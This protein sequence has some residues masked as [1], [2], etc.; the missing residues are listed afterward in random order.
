MLIL[1]SP[2]K[3]LDFKPTGVTTHTLPDFLNDS[4]KLIR[5]MKK[6]SIGDLQQLMSISEALASLN[7]QRYRQ[8][9]FPFTKENAKQAV[10]A[11]KGDV[12]VGLEADTL[13]EDDLSF[14]QDHV[15]ILSGLYGMLKPLDLIQPYRLEMGVRLEQG[16]YS[17]LYEFW[18]QKLTR[19]LNDKILQQPEDTR[20][21]INLASQEYFQ[22]IRTAKV[23]APVINIKFLEDRGGDLQFISFNA[24][25]AR[26]IMTRFIIRHRLSDPEAIKTFN[27]SS[28]QY[29]D[30]LSSANEWT[31]IRQQDA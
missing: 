9:D 28:Y 12:Y 16:K 10:L 24:K 25:K 11:F 1:L 29:A 15:I 5:V 13:D 26:G 22:A 2:A 4:K 8:F 3:T 19:H 23:K 18:T 31:F 7:H 6:K 27:E 21:V 14:A 30:E 17:N 20:V